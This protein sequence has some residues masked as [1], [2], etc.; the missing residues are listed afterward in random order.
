MKRKVSIYNQLR[1]KF[2]NHKKS[3][4]EYMLFKELHLHK[5][6]KE[7]KEIKLLKERNRIP[8]LLALGLFLFH[9]NFF[10]ASK[11]IE[12]KHLIS[13][14]FFFLFFCFYKLLTYQIVIIY[15]SGGCSK[16]KVLSTEKKEVLTLMKKVNNS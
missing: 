7:I 5:L 6:K 15:K 3:I 14:L 9:F 1:L 10:Y 4:S 11:F 2:Q 16:F 12:K 8:N 13:T